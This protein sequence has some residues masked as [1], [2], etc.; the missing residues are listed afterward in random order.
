MSSRVVAERHTNALRMPSN[1]R[2]KNGVME[3]GA[4]TRENANHV[5]IRREREACCQA[6]NEERTRSG[7]GVEDTVNR[8]SAKYDMQHRMR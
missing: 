3:S 7:T 1:A 8:V 5:S 2:K 6:G 4:R